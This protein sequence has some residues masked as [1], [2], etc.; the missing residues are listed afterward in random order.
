MSIDPLTEDYTDW[1]PYV[2]SGNRVID[3]RELEGLEPYRLFGSEEDAAGNW[4]EIYNYH[5]I[6][7]GQEYGSMIGKSIDA[8]GKA[9]YSYG[10]PNGGGNSAVL[11]SP[12]PPGT[13]A[14]ADIHSH[15]SSEAG[16]SNNTFSDSDKHSNIKN[17]VNGYLTTPSG[18]LQKF[19]VE[20]QTSSILRTDLSFDPYD[21]E[22]F[23]VFLMSNRGIGPF[24]VKQ[25]NVT[26][27]D[28]TTT[29]IP[30]P[31]STQN[32]NSKPN[33]TP[34]PTPKPKP[35]PELKPGG[36]RSPHGFL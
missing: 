4:A 17:K 19:S 15:G 8:N 10:H 26:L 14:T 22:T 11:S 9:W 36:G 6:R 7:A 24:P 12:P 27:K 30:S 1:S 33:P 18:T 16:Y 34:N 31:N 25:G 5:S 32:S 3:A 35:K 20:T 23:N 29:K 28:P 21:E 13:I 2:F